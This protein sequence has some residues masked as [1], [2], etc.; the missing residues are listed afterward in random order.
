MDADARRSGHLAQFAKFGSGNETSFGCLN[1]ISLNHRRGSYDLRVE[2]EL[3]QSIDGVRPEGKSCA[4]FA[5]T[6]SPLDD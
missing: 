4:D 5:N 1:H 3:A 2:A 6:W